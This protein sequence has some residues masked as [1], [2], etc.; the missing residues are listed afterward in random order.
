MISGGRKKRVFGPTQV[1]KNA[2]H[3]AVSGVV[4]RPAGEGG[5]IPS[6]ISGLALSRF[7]RLRD[8]TRDRVQP[9]THLAHFTSFVSRENHKSLEKTR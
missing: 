7:S 1:C 6:H 4:V 8:I 3:S 9:H 2:H 5:N